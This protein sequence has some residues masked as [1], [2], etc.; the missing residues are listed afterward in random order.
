ML[1]LSGA[2]GA[3][4]QSAAPASPPAA[5]TAAAPAAAGSFTDEELTKFA[6]AATELNKIQADAGVPAADKQPKMLAAVQA[7]GLDPA[8]FNTIA[9]AAQSD[10]ALQQKIQAAAAKTPAASAGAQPATPGQ[11]QQ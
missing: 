6:S 10:P 3:L 7:S 2:T 8:R 1:A 9:E 11:P 5:P 4:A